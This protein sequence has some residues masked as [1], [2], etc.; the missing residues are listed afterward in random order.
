MQELLILPRAGYTGLRT[1]RLAQRRTN[2]AISL[3]KM[4]PQ[5]NT[6]LKNAAPRRLW[7][8]NAAFAPIGCSCQ[9]ARAFVQP[10][11]K[12]NVNLVHA[13]KVSRERMERPESP[14]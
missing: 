8:A 14:R 4:G 6:Q 12:I 5:D 13:S 1:A 10:L 7:H 3:R 9:C 2:N 11:P